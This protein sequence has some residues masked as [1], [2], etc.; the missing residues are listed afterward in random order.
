[1]KKIS[2]FLGFGFLLAPQHHTPEH[3]VSSCCC[4]PG[5]CSRM[6]S[7]PLLWQFCPISVTCGESPAL[8]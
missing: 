4:H 7:A 8:Q 1:M 2:T 6:L 5:L 3:T